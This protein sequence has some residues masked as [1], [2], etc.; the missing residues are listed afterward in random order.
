GSGAKNIKIIGGR[1][2]RPH[3]QPW[4]V[5]TSRDNG[6]RWCGASLIS[7]RWAVSAAHCSLPASRLTLH[8][9]EHNLQTNEGSEQ[10]IRAEKVF[11]HPQYN[12]STYD[13]DFMLI[14]LSQ[15]AVFNERVKAISLATT[16]SKE[17]QKCLVSGWGNQATNGEN[18]ANLLQC[19]DVPVI[20][21]S[22]CEAS[23][24]GSITKNMLCAGFLEGGRD[25]CQLAAEPKTL[26]SSEDVSVVLTPSPGRASRLLLHLGDHNLQ[27]NEGSEQRIRAEK[28]F[29]HPQYNPSTYDND[30]M[31]IKLSQPAVFNE[32]VKAI[33]LATTCS[34]AGQ[35]CL[36][37]G[38]GN[39]ATN[40]GEVSSTL[41]L[42]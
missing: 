13:N 38:W 2:C 12:P 5:F 8:L 32:R 28:V 17:G 19:L 35:K 24:P 41:M 6:N 1:E 22:Q 7:P 4:Q 36:V 23:Y 27:T 14:K 15:P 20:A 11:P 33:S 31:L 29:T 40:G 9:G 42:S 37:S 25:S 3:S 30:F 34:K 16:C 18:Y 21:R 39:Q 26:R 10:R